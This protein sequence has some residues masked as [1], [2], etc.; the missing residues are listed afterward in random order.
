MK[1]ETPRARWRFELSWGELEVFAAGDPIPTTL[2]STAAVLDRLH[3]R[4]RPALLRTH[5]WP[6]GAYAAVWPVNRP[7]PEPTG[8][9]EPGLQTLQGV[10][11]AQIQTLTCRSCTAR[12]QAVYPDLGIPFFGRHLTAHQLISGCPSCGND[13]ATSRIQALALLPPP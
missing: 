4:F 12:C 1:D 2:Q 7:L 13:F 9:T 3:D 11:L 8:N 5:R 6:D 10:V